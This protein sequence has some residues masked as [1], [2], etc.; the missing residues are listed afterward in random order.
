[1]ISSSDQTLIPEA[2]PAGTIS[3][4]AIGICSDRYRS[5]FVTLERGG[6]FMLRD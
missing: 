6:I 3:R 5:I 1:M 2:I 4:S